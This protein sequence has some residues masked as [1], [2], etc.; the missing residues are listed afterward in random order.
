MKLQE[1]GVFVKFCL[2]FKL[3]I[4]NEDAFI[5]NSRQSLEHTGSVKHGY[6]EAPGTGDF[7]SL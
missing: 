7:T 3:I 1:R 6:N 2:I 4:N 5:D